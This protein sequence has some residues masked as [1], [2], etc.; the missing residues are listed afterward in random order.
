M[1]KSSRYV[2]FV[3]SRSDYGA[4]SFEWIY[5]IQPN[6]ETGIKHTDFITK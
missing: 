1:S 6:L 4:N 3:S 5:G 2:V